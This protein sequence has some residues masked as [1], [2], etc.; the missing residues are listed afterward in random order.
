LL[1][2][3]AA[4]A[5]ARNCPHRWIRST[6]DAPPISSECS[7]GDSKSVEAGSLNSFNALFFVFATT[8][9]LHFFSQG[10]FFGVIENKI[11]FFLVAFATDF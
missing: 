10:N 9:A 3:Y 11:H 1:S 8:R 2:V 6:R 4:L 5:E 7:R